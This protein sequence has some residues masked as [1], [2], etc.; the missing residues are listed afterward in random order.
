MTGSDEIE[1]LKNKLEIVQK[2]KTIL[3]N[4]I[5]LDCLMRYSEDPKFSAKV[6]EKMEDLLIQELSNKESLNMNKSDGQSKHT[7]QPPPLPQQQNKPSFIQPNESTLTS[8]KIGKIKTD[9]DKFRKSE[10]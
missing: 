1:N 2:F 8:I 5:L 9:S 6:F 3:A 4:P 10:E 7:I